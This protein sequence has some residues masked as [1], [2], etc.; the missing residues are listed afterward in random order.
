MIDS[1]IVGVKLPV[2]GTGAGVM[3][4]AGVGVGLGIGTAV[5]VGCAVDADWD[6]VKAGISAAWTTKVRVRLLVIPVASFQRTVIVWLPAAKSFGGVKL[7]FPVE[8]TCM[9]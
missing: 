7:Q 4:E 2:T 1:R 3:L 9:F 5:G 8:P 6:A